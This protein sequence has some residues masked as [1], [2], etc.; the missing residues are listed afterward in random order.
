MQAAR[1]RSAT[2]TALILPIFIAAL[3]LILISTWLVPPSSGQGIPQLLGSSLSMDPQG[4]A[5]RPSLAAAPDGSIVAAWSQH[6]NPAAWEYSATYVKRWAAVGAH[7]VA[8]RQC[9]WAIRGALA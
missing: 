1:S 8:D 7:R 9:A 6:R 5:S 4:W 2:T 3:S